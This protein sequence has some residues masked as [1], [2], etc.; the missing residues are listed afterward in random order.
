MLSWGMAVAVA[1]VAGLTGVASAIVFTVNPVQVRLSAH[2][3]SMTLTLK[4]ES[5]EPSR[6]QVSVFA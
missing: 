6:F 2:T 4:N 5:P 1:C 3:R